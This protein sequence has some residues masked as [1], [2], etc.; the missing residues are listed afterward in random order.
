MFC[1]IEILKGKCM[2]SNVDVSK[3]A[4]RD[5]KLDKAKLNNAKNYV[6]TMKSLKS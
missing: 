5:H 1:I 6:S 4:K 3:E 2:P